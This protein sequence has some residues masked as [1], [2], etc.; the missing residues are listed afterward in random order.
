MKHVAVGVRDRVVED[1]GLHVV[2]IFDTN[3]H[4]PDKDVCLVKDAEGTVLVL[5]TGEVRTEGVFED[6]FV[7]ATLVVPKRIT[8]SAD[9]AWELEEYLDAPELIALTDVH[10][11][12]VEERM[13]KGFWEMQQAWSDVGLPPA[14]QKAIEHAKGALELLTPQEKMRV[15]AAARKYETFLRGQYPSKWKYSKDNLLWLPNGKLGLIDLPRMGLRHWG[16][17]LGW[18]YWPEWYTMTPEAWSDVDGY[19]KRLEKLFALVEAHKPEEVEI[20]SL[21]VERMLWLGCLTRIIGGF[22]D[23]A[24][25]ISHAQEIVADEKRREAFLA[26]LHG[27]LDHALNK[28]ESRL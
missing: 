2:R 3:E 24:Q 27:L 26:F 16:Y 10:Q 6:G 22:Y 23:V 18:I 5:R 12:E 9:P 8:W 25:N 17:D 14:E 15:L 20:G 4:E 1:R 28:V 11:S 7:G 13:V 21:V 19:I